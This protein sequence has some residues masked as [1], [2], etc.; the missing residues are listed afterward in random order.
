VAAILGALLGVARYYFSGPRLANF[1]V[2][3]LFKN[4]RGCV[5]LESVDWPFLG[6]TG[7]TSRPPS[8]ICAST[9][10]RAARSW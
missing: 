9:P 10:R 1:L 6:I 5:T 3:T 8:P 7:A 4:V 2:Q